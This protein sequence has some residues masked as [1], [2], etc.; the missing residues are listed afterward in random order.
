MLRVS[1]K[2]AYAWHRAW[3][4]G[5]SAALVSKGPAGQ[6]CRLEEAQ[7]RRLEAELDAG[8]GAQGLG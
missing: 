2:S 4:A 7:L 8:P 3:Q 5:G 1:V 6:R